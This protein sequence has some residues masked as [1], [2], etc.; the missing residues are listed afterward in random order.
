M[1]RGAPIQSSSIPERIPSL[2]NDIWYLILDQLH[3]DAFPA[4]LE[5]S[6]VSTRLRCLAVRYIYRVVRV[7]TE[8]LSNLDGPKYSCGGTI[9]NKIA[10]YSHDV[11]VESAVPDHVLNTLLIKIRNLEYLR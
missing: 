3:L 2:P 8:Q 11:I 6:L 10:L 9:R 4:I 1:E 5:L 7:S